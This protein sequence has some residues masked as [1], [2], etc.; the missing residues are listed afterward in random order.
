MKR[1]A[2]NKGTK[3]LVKANSGSFKKGEHRSR[4]TEFKKGEMSR[5]KHPLW[6]GGRRNTVNGYIMVN[7][8]NHPRAYRNEVYEHIIIA[9][10]KL[11]R[12]LED[13]ERVHHI[14][15]IKYDNRPENIM[16]FGSHKEHMRHHLLGKKR[17]KDFTWI[18]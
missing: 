6:K 10:R 8:P 17:N 5:E 4:S 11:G 7:V 1:I 13:N 18:K 9:E 16:I 14:N 15:G 12:Y 2:W 3:G